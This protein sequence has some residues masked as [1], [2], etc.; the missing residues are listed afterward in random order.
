M[1]AIQKQEM[2]DQIKAMKQEI[3]DV[4][5]TTPIIEGFCMA[6][7]KPG[8]GPA[9]RY[10]AAA[11][12]AG[13]LWELLSAATSDDGRLWELFS[14]AASDDGRLWELFFAAVRDDGRL[15]ELFAAARDDGRLQEF[16]ATAHAAGRLD[17][18][19]ELIKNTETE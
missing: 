4:F 11:R 8:Y 3:T 15:W 16:F 12:A 9:T 5:L 13:R 10:I 18:I 2:L 17:E 14:A 7:K 6:W 19:E 1:N